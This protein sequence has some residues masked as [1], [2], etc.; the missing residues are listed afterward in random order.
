MLDCFCCA[1]AG[2]L[3][4]LVWLSTHMVR[5][6]ILYFR[7]GS[8]WLWTSVVHL[9]LVMVVMFCGEF[10]PCVPGVCR[11]YLCAVFTTSENS[12]RFQLLDTQT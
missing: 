5:T 11:A 1:L 9:V 7:G 3:C 4:E 2:R 8:E 6:G 10:S 12:P